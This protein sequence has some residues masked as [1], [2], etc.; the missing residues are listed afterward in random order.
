M[1]AMSA[2]ISGG[3]IRANLGSAESNRNT[4]VI[5]AAIMTPSRIAKI[6][7]KPNC[8]NT[9]ATIAMTIGIGNRLMHLRIQPLSPRMNINAP[10]A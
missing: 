4:A 10:V 8:R 2:P 1:P 5:G 6:K 9:P 3:D 7:F